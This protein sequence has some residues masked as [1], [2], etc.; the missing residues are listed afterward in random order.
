M[1]RRQI[2]PAQSFLGADQKSDHGSRR[3]PLAKKRF[4]TVLLQDLGHGQRKFTAQETGIMPHDH[5]GPER[6]QRRRGILALGGQIIRHRLGDHSDV[7][8]GEVSG[9]QASPP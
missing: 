8:K 9:D 2:D 5:Q 3:R 1:T 7:I 6:R 4:I